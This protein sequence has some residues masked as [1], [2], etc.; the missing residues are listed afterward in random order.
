MEGE[1]SQKQQEQLGCVNLAFSGVEPVVR[2][3]GHWADNANNALQNQT[4]ILELLR[5]H[6]KLLYRMDSKVK[7]LHEQLFAVNTRLAEVER[8]KEANREMVALIVP[9]L[10]TML[11]QMDPELIAQ[12]GLTEVARK[13][14]E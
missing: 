2:G 4:N 3:V 12:Y 9:A 10:N 5:I 13:F 14:A 6:S 1:L 7:N 11:S 8:E